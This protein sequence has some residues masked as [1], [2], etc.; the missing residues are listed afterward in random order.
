MIKI[1]LYIA[2]SLDGYIARPDGAV[3]WLESFPHPEGQD[4]GYANFLKGIGTVILGRKTYEEILSFDVP[5]PYATLQTVVC[6]KNS[7]LY[8][9][10][11]NTTLCPT[12]SE[13]FLMKVKQK[14]EK[15]IWLVGGGEVVASFLRLKAVDEMWITQL[16]VLLGQGLPLFPGAFQKLTSCLK[17]FSPLKME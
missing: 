13:E 8:L 6:T 15:D 14:A 10:T 4:Y 12:L 3:D 1:K 5:W 9:P 11:P 16:P 2:C 17:M 7:E